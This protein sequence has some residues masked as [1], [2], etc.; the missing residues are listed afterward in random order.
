MGWVSQGREAG[1]SRAGLDAVGVSHGPGLICASLV[2]LS[3]AKGLG[4]AWALPLGGLT[5]LEAPLYA[6]PPEH[7]RLAFPQLVLF[8][9]GGNGCRLHTDGFS[10]AIQT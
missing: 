2:G 7:G 3:E 4:L 9:R 5:H 8:V 6:A 1:V 10:T